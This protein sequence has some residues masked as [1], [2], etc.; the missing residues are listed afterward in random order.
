MKT[1]VLTSTS[2][3]SPLNTLSNLEPTLAAS[4]SNTI[5]KYSLKKTNKSNHLAPLI[6]AELTTGFHLLGSPVESPTFAQEFFNDQLSN[7]Q[8]K[9]TLLSKLGHYQPTN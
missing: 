4:I 7:V 1:R 3:H 6:L 2:G 8:T 5:A 9:I